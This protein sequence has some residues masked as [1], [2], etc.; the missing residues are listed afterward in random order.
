LSS[1]R[2]EGLPRAIMFKDL[3]RDNKR[4][5]IQGLRQ[6]EKKERNRNL[7]SLKGKLHDI[8]NLQS[9]QK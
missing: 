7:I 6:R 1:R 4:D 3:D 5:K 9:L 2:E 8:M